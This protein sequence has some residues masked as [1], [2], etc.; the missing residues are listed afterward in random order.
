MCDNS[1]NVKQCLENEVSS[2]YSTNRD[3]ESRG[4]DS[5]T[6]S[7]CLVLESQKN[8]VNT[9]SYSFPYIPSI[10]QQPRES[11][12]SFIGSHLS[13]SRIYS[14]QDFGRNKSCF[15]FKA[16]QEADIQLFLGRLLNKSQFDSGDIR[17]KCNDEKLTNYGNNPENIPS[18][19]N[20]PFSESAFPNQNQF[21]SDLFYSTVNRIETGPSLDKNVDIYN[22]LGSEYKNIKH[23]FSF[24]IDSFENNSPISQASDTTFGI[25]S[26]DSR[27][28]SISHQNSQSQ[29]LLN[30]NEPLIFNKNG[31]NT[32]RK[33]KLPTISDLY[34]GNF[35]SY[36][37]LESLPSMNSSLS[38][39]STEFSSDSENR[40][41][42]G[43]LTKKK[44]I[45]ELV[46]G[47][48]FDLKSLRIG[49][50]K[51]AAPGFDRK[52]ENKSAKGYSYIRGKVFSLSTEQS[53][54][55]TIQECLEVSDEREISEMFKEIS[56]NIEI[57]VTDMFGNYVV[58]KFLEFGSTN[59]REKLSKA[60]LGSVPT[61]SMHVYGCRVVQRI[62]SSSGIEIQRRVMGELKPVIMD[63]IHDVNGNHV[64]QKAVECVEISDLLF[65]TRVIEGKALSLS[66]HPFGCHVLQRLIERLYNHSFMDS[67]LEQL[68]DQ[69]PEL[70]K[71]QHGNY[72]IQH[73]LKF[74]NRKHKQAVINCIKKNFVGFRS[75][76][77]DGK[78]WITSY[79]RF[80]QKP[81]WKLC[82]PEAYKYF[83]RGAQGYVVGQYIPTF[84]NSKK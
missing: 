6:L 41:R 53:G 8:S 58:Q 77:Q 65:I 3:I 10:T 82:S 30:N 81:V 56:P 54:S 15:E 21:T 28:Q 43:T 59:I 26:P 52:R 16:D 63:C 70:T 76:D 38:S 49:N 61:L 71:N 13:D 7:S 69:I 62:I 72:V 48:L 1:N 50:P 4:L 84:K 78:L 80:D 25:K 67:F 42:A 39:N 66:V 37:G 23:D 17:Q 19:F 24:R 79:C 20:T 73:I 40:Q 46:G 35:G 47:K 75:L 51:T 27:I 36:R 44:E 14:A 34:Q 68:K 5:L 57:L 22:K 74:G 9:K 33:P 11:Q 83:A 55:R 31:L 64:V 29:Y 45:K 18:E 12:N 2:K 60:L 32:M